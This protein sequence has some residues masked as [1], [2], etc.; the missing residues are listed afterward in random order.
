MGKENQYA[1]LTWK[2]ICKTHLKEVKVTN[3][4]MQSK[5]LK[6]TSGMI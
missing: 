4:L 6:A 1:M 2:K 5:E 3:F